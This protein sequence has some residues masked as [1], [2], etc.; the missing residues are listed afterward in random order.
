MFESTRISSL[1]IA[2]IACGSLGAN[3]DTSVVEPDSYIVQARDVHAAT[4]AVLAVGGA[5]TDRF[6]II[7]AV[8]ARLSS[9]S[10][11]A[12]RVH[13]GV[14]ISPDRHLSVAG[15]VKPTFFPT[16]IGAKLLHQQGIDGYGV[17]VAV[18]DTGLW[19]K[20]ATQ[21][22]A[23][24][25]KRIL[26]QYDVIAERTKPDL[27]KDGTYEIDIDD[28]NGHGT[29]VVDLPRLRGRFRGWDS[30][31]FLQGHTPLVVDG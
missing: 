26:A 14:N 15:P 19:K 6:E 28:V 18:L 17:T 13:P 25:Q 24:G 16:L 27:Y 31:C 23:R 7:D 22:D 4:E 12:L 20:T 3:A 2:L 29:H 10:A 5:I 1:A 9:E 8:A 30:S 21:D 11:G